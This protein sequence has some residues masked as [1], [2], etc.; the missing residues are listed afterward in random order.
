MKQKKVLLD[1][2]SLDHRKKRP[3]KNLNCAINEKEKNE[4]TDPNK[5][6]CHY[7]KGDCMR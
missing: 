3:L 7:S 4:P 2:P 1:F 5:L 6:I